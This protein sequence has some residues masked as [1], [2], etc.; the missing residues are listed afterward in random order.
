MEETFNHSANLLLLH[1]WRFPCPACFENTEGSLR[2]LTLPVLARVGSGPGMGLGSSG[3]STSVASCRFLGQHQF[4]KSYTAAQRHAYSWWKA[5]EHGDFCDRWDSAWRMHGG[6]RQWVMS[7]LRYAHGISPPFLFFFLQKAVQLPEIQLACWRP[8][9]ASD[10]SCS[11]CSEWLWSLAVE[12][13]SS[14][15]MNIW[16][17]NFFP[18][19]YSDESQEKSQCVL[20]IYWWIVDDP[21][22]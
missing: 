13:V 20:T 9:Q 7:G 10:I 18:H 22:I 6:R 14:W 16:E 8:E 3:A 2:P 1:L 4:T 21:K 11:L 12:A 5:A 15:S 17:K 19:K